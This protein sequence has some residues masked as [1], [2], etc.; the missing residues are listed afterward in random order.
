MTIRVWGIGHGAWWRRMRWTPAA[1]TPWPMTHGP[2]PQGRQWGF[3]LIGLLFALAFVVIV[4]VA[5]GTLTAQTFGISRASKERFI[6]TALARE[7]IDLVRALRDDNWF[8]YG[9]GTTSMLWRGGNPATGVGSPEEQA[10]A[11]CNGTW[12]ISSENQKL[13][14]LGGAS[15]NGELFL[16]VGGSE[17]RYDHDPSGTPTIYRRTVTIGTGDTGSGDCGETVSSSQTT[18]PD[19][20]LVTS[21]V[22]W[23]EHPTDPLRSVE[24]REELFDWIKER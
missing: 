19:R 9:P 16:T 12:I 14:P 17:L 7:G 15:P 1:R 18:P 8:A 10:R 2:S 23:R 22:D 3:T 11:I 13:N 6:A 4:V 21:R 20:V 24:L 5:I